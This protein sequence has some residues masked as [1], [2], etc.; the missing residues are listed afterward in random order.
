MIR[1]LIT[2]DV[3]VGPGFWLDVPGHRDG[4]D[5][6][7]VDSDRCFLI[8]H[9]GSWRGMLDCIR[10]I[11]RYAANEASN[12]CPPVVLVINS[13][14]AL[15]DITRA[16]ASARAL[17]SDAAAGKLEA[18][19]YAD[20]QP[21]RGHWT[22]AN[23][24]WRQLMRILKEFRGIVIA[25]SRAASALTAE[26]VTA[27]E[28]LF[29]RRD[30]PHELLWQVDACV[31]LRALAPPMLIAAPRL[32]DIL[33][34]PVPDLTVAELIFDRLKFDPAAIADPYE[35]PLPIEMMANEL[36][37]AESTDVLNRSY[38]EHQ[39]RLARGSEP[40]LSAAYRTRRRY[41][42]R[43]VDAP[44]F[45]SKAT[46]LQEL[47]QRCEKLTN[48]NIDLNHPTIQSAIVNRHRILIDSILQAVRA[49]DN[50]GDLD[51]KFN[52]YRS[53]VNRG[54]AAAL[55][56]VYDET[57]SRLMRQSDTH[58]SPNGSEDQH[59]PIER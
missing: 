22:Q 6:L 56:A 39:Q 5:Q 31:A 23:N 49:A 55:N 26:G 30:L 25:T 37:A 43:T 9:D 20:V 32:D 36:F 29:Q 40:L 10:E 27:S 21:E 46:T 53:D 16:G 45:L 12:G 14:T 4:N 58:L 8:D 41:L 1:T 48:H 35:I 18:D 3:R 33:P 57:K 50:L 19:P 15:S 11:S 17:C 2:E 34:Q 59:I 54:D 47:R 38:T 51:R 42:V 24:R 28:A 7:P 52:H 44:V 13:V